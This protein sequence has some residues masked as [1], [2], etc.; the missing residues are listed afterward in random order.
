MNSMKKL[1]VS[2]ILVAFLAF[3]LLQVP[4]VYSAE[5]SAPDEALTFLEDVVNLDMPKYNATLD[6]YDVRYPSHLNGLVQEN[7]VYL[8]ES[9]ENKIQVAFAFV[10]KTLYHYGLFVIDGSPLY[11]QPQPKT[12]LDVA[13]EIVQK[14]QI[15]SNVSNMG[16]MIDFDGM[17]NILNT[18]DKIE[19]LE[20]RLG[21][22]KLKIITSKMDHTA[23]EW[24]HTLD[25]VDFP[26]ITFEFQKGTFCGLSNIWRVYEIGSTD[27]NV[28]R[29]EAINIAIKHL[30]DF[31]WKASSNKGDIVEV[32]NFAIVE[33]Q[34]S[35]ELITTRSREPLT[36]YP[37]W[38]IVLYLDTIYPGSVNRISL[39]IWADTGEV[40]SCIPLSIGGGFPLDQITESTPPLDIIIPVAAATMIAIALVAVVIKK[41]HK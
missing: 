7:V 11:S 16:N 14:F 17:R 18:V 40:I 25:G 6:I 41:R 8:L 34:L 30:D 38:Q 29:E 37:C 24:M 12:T 32:T 23:F 4:M 33:E 2:L 19:D 3:L 36:L 22:I 39:A 21:N 35:A 5:W 10:N 28:S 13:M 31:S 26:G 1:Q 20:T 15:Y 27:V 9:N